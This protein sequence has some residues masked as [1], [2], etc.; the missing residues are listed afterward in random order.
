VCSYVAGCTRTEDRTPLRGWH[1]RLEAAQMIS[2]AAKARPRCPRRVCVLISK[3]HIMKRAR[4]VFCQG[5]GQLA[6]TPRRHFRSQGT[7]ATVEHRLIKTVAAAASVHKH[8]QPFCTSAQ[9][10]FSYFPHCTVYREVTRWP[11]GSK[12]AHHVRPM[13][14]VEPQHA[15]GK[16]TY[17]V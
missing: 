14:A 17:L 16:A 3:A 10:G 1:R 15:Q 7:A 13:R 6:A 12:M 2:A 5:F 4:F 11:E 8:S 9:I